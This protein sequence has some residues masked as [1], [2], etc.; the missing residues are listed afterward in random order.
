MKS[1]IFSFDYILNIFI[2]IW[3]LF[4]IFTQW[5]NYFYITVPWNFYTSNTNYAYNLK[6]TNI[7]IIYNAS[8]CNNKNDDAYL[9]Y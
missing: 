7:G 5:R 2:Q 6:F 4:Y 9:N 1:T 8:F 3:I